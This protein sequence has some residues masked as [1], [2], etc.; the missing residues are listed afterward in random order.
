ELQGAAQHNQD[1]LYTEIGGGFRRV[2]GIETKDGAGAA[3]LFRSRAARRQYGG[4]GLGGGPVSGRLGAG[5]GGP[6]AAGVRLVVHAD[7]RAGEIVMSFALIS[8]KPGRFS[9]MALSWVLFAAGIAAYFYVSAA[10]HR[11]NPED[12]VM[13]TIAQMSRG[14]LDA[15]LHPA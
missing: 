1:V 2:A 9:T 3:G 10:R 7:G 12:R 5:Q 11:E 4:G 15:A 8:S 6:C 13:P 14:V